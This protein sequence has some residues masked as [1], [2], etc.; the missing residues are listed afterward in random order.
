VNTLQPPKREGS[1]GARGEAPRSRETIAAFPPVRRAEDGGPF[2]IGVLPGEGV[3]PEVVPA[4]LAV[5]AAASEDTPHE[6][7]LRSGGAIG[8]EAFA[9]GG[10]WLTDAVIDFCRETFADGG[11][12]LCGPGGG[13][14][15]YDLRSEFDLFCK[16]TPVRSWPELADAGPLRR[17]ATRGVDILFVRENCAGVYQGV[18]SER[19][20]GGR[21]RHAELRFEYSDRCVERILRVACDVAARRRGRIAVVVKIDGIPGISALWAEQAQELARASGA[22]LEILEIDNACYQLAAE[23]SCFDVVVSPNLFGDILADVG[24]LQLASRGMS[25][26]G[27]FAAGGAAVYQ[28][29]H[30]A[31][32]DIAG[33]NRANPVG[34]IQSLAMLVRESFGLEALGDRMLRAAREVLAEGWRTPDVAGPD[35]QVVGTQELARLIAERARTDGRR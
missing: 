5:L 35:S 27:N 25:F 30:G 7:T 32:Y 14:F 22:E 16:L 19:R 13:R 20:E 8:R 23:G 34:Q 3:G 4:A 29:G 18:S 15:V 11:A 26:S 12:V 2:V 31:A 24:A 10:R 33:K 6:L 17:A 21:I 1:G 28:T 9:L